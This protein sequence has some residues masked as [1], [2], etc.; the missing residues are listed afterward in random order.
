M[1]TSEFIAQQESLFAAAM[2]GDT[3][4]VMELIDGE[5]VDVNRGDGDL[6][7]VRKRR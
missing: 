7:V 6:Y 2:R 1:A 5:G 4:R 3:K